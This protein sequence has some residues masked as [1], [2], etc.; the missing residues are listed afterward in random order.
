V[1]CT[2]LS[3]ARGPIAGGSNR[4]GGSTGRIDPPWVPAEGWQ[5]YSGQNNFIEFGKAPYVPGENGGIHGHVIYVS[6]PPFDDPQMLVQTQWEPLVPNVTMHN[7]NQ[8][9]P[10]PYDGKYSFPSVPGL[11]PTTGKPS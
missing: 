1:D 9:Q 6:T 10:A 3:I 7:W 4:P 8:F 2:G 11:S 5:G